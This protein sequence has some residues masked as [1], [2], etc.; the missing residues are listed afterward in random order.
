MKKE[1]IKART[2]NIR[3]FQCDEQVAYVKWK[4]SLLCVD[5]QLIASQ[6]QQT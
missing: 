3:A 5:A 4:E 2:K 6:M 1:K